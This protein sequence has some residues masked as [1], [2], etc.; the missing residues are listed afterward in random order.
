MSVKKFSAVFDN[1]ILLIL[2]IVFLISLPSVP[3]QI[4]KFK[5]FSAG[6]KIP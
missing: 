2:E 3:V 6:S 4:F 5:L 1:F